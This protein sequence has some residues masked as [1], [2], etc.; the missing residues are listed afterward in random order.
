MGPVVERGACSEQL[1]PMSAS[2]SS[3]SVTFYKK[4]LLPNTPSFST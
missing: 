2:R 3:Q 1:R 4:V